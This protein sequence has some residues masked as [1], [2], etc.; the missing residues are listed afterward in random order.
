MIDDKS[1]VFEKY[2][3]SEEEMKG[4]KKKIRQFYEEQ[5]EILVST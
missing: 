4:M 1:G 5:N 3:K 2:R